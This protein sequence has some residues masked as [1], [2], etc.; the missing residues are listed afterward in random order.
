MNQTGNEKKYREALEAVVALLEQA[1]N[2]QQYE[3]GLYGK[4]GTKKEIYA[5]AL[6]KAKEA[7]E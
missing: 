5:T 1:Q 7:L 2:P 3:G 6:V 4:K